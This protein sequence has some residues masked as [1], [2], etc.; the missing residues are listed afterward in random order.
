MISASAASQPSATLCLVENELSN[1]ALESGQHI[2]TASSRVTGPAKAS[3][4]GCQENL[5]SC[6]TDAVLSA[7]SK[8][9]G[10]RLAVDIFFA[11]PLSD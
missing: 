3:R 6:T 8:R 1:L 5:E 7:T 10:Q 4:S 9:V 11:K 2:A